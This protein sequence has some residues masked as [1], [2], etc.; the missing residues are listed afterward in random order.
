VKWSVIE[1]RG[2]IYVISID[3]VIAIGDYEIAGTCVRV[4]GS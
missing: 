3:K 4:R 2:W 1:D